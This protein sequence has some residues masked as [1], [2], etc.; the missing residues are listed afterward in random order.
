MAAN[1]KD[2]KVFGSDFRAMSLTR[3]RSYYVIL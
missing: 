2:V 1:V 3:S